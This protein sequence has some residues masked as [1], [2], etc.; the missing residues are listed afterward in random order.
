MSQS[1]GLNRILGGAIGVIALVS[2]LSSGWVLVTAEQLRDATDAR[3]RSNQLI[4]GLDG[5]RAAML[6]QETGLRGYLIT[7]R[8]GSLEPY[9]AGRA[10]LDEAIGRLGGLIGQDPERMRLLADAMTA[11]RTWQTETGEAA[12]RMAADPAKRAEA[13]RIET[14]GQ[15]KQLFDTF[16]QKLAA[17]EG[18]EGAARTALAVRVAQGERNESV[19]LWGER[20]SRS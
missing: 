1:L 12:I 18:L 17:I 15:G 8:E 10:A 2:V 11:A 20:S 5:F 3:S 6:N 9:H 19:A 4:R 7:G 14:D 16:R 13:V